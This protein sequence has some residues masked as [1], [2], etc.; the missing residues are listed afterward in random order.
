ML[1]CA[2]KLSVLRSVMK[3]NGIDFYIL[4]AYD[5]HFN[6]DIPGYW[7]VIK[8]LTGFSGSAAT[9][10]VTPVFAG[11]WTDSRYFIQAERELAGS[12]FEFVKIR[13]DGN[14]NYLDF[15]VEN[16]KSG[17]KLGFDG[18]TFPVTAFRKLK[19]R[20][21]EKEVV[22]VT[23]F[24]PLSAIW[25]DRPPLPGSVAFDHPAVICGM[26]RSVKI[27]LVRGRMS[28]RKVPFH[29]LARPD[30]IMW[31]L[32]IRG[33]DLDYSPVILSFALISTDQVLLFAD[34]S[35]IPAKLAYEFDKLG[36]VILPYEDAADIISSVTDGFKVLADPETLS[37]SLYE[38][39][40]EKAVLLE[41]KTI[42]SDLKAVR[43]KTEIKNTEEVMIKDGV[44]LTR[45]FFWLENLP[46]EG[47]L[48]EVTLASKILEYRSKQEAFIGPSFET[49]IAF[50][51]NSALPHYTPKSGT[52][53]GIGE[54]GILLIDSGGQYMGGTTDITRTISVGV[55]TAKQK[56]DF[57]LVLKGHIDLADSKFPEGTKGYQLDAFARRPLWENGQNY[58]HGTGHGVGFCLNVHEGPQSISPAANKTAI[59]PGMVISNEPAIYRA[60]E[61]GIR[62]ENLLLCY[63]DEITEFGKFLKFDT[64]SLCYIDKSLIDKMLL[65]REEIRWLDKYHSVVFDK[66]G[67]SLSEE[68]K[69]WLK[70][71]TAPL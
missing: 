61:Y 26:E 34:E 48:T 50:N 5:P 46:K 64:I 68:E 24:D 12:G 29:F 41:D 40:S 38:C 35:K 49:I 16:I 27:E 62:T 67:S 25:S 32:N 15:I 66:L 19:S 65:D 11:L 70:E 71:K 39:F 21:K 17:S 54:R 53:A 43:N 28:E 59:R 45:F 52:E 3:G 60:G 47:A 63:E 37:V 33:N 10:I 9:V 69:S 31:L 6:E 56:H 18:R 42:I 20:L 30:E 22:Y 23:D 58:G 51:E 36:I 4:P 7:Q 14:N 1:S 2:E 8:W 13:V 55:P 57:T 44:A